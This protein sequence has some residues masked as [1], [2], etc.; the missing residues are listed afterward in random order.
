M[1]RVGS[2]TRR[3]RLWVRIALTLVGTT[4]L[5]VGGFL[6]AVEQEYGGW[7]ATDLGHHVIAHDEVTGGAQVLG[8]DGEVLFEAT[9]LEEAEAWVE[10]QRDRD[11]GVSIL[12]LAGGAGLVIAGL[13]PWGRRPTGATTVGGAP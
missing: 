1:D 7:E 4:F 10:A 13:V 3:G 11:F 12:M 9:S 2:S 5:L 8:E 6:W